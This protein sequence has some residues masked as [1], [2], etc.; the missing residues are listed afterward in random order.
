[1]LLTSDPSNSPLVLVV[2]ILT[3]TQ[4]LDTLVDNPTAPHGFFSLVGISR[5]YQ[6]INPSPTDH[7][8]WYPL[9]LYLD[10]Y[11]R[12]GWQYNPLDNNDTK[13][14]TA[15]IDQTP[16]AGI[17]RTPGVIRSALVAPKSHR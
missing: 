1:M 2:W 9:A 17:T 15:S 7:S 12:H 11:P 4:L 14:S 8:C 16:R 10:H 5:R 6:R 3:E 13:F